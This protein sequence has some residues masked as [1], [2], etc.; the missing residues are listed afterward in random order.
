ME[1]FSMRNIEQGYQINAKKKLDHWSILLEE[2]LLMIQRYCR[3]MEGWDSPYYHSESANR[4]VLAAA[5]WRA[6]WLALEEFPIKKR[7]ITREGKGDLWFYQVQ[8]AREEYIEIKQK[9]NIK[10]ANDALSEAIQDVKNLIIKYEDHVR[11]GLTFICHGIQK[12][13]KS[14]IEQE[15]QEVIATAKEINCDAIAWSFPGETRKLWERIQGKRTFY[16]GIL[17][18]AKIAD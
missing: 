1:G 6:G 9:W 4:G 18:L 12:K 13:L 15:I 8:M 17:L 3:L 11:I 16:P 10:K 14:G 5:A 2:W 7:H